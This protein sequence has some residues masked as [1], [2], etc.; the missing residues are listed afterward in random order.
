MPQKLEEL[1]IVVHDEWRSESF[2]G[3]FRTLRPLARA[4]EVL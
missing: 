4:V 3:S 1:E 2:G